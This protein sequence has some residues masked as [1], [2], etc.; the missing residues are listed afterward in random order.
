MT[1]RRK[2]NDFLS[3]RSHERRSFDWYVPGAVEVE[4]AAVLM[5]VSTG[6]PLTITCALPLLLKL[7]A[8]LGRTVA[9]VLGEGE[10]ARGVADEAGAA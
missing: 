4:S 8:L 5:L 1:K 6:L 7:E 10:A 9:E 2:S 3:Y